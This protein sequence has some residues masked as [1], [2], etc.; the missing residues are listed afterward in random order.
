VVLLLAATTATIIRVVTARLLLS[1]RPS[2]A[3]AHL[4]SSF[5][6]AVLFS[7]KFQGAVAG[8]I[9]MPATATIILIAAIGGHRFRHSVI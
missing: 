5:N 4:L 6:F 1:Y 9:K 2:I 3:A 7:V 8:I